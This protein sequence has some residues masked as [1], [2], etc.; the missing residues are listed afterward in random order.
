L[1]R[2]RLR[3]G[4]PGRRGRLCGRVRALDVHLGAG[5]DGL[6]DVLV[7]LGQPEGDEVDPLRQERGA[8]VDEFRELGHGLDE[9]R[10]D[11]VPD[12]LRRL[13]PD[14]GGELDLED[15][16]WEQL[17][18]R[19][20]DRREWVVDP[21]IGATPV[22]VRPVDAVKVVLAHHRELGVERDADG[23]VAGELEC[24][25]VVERSHDCY[26][27]NSIPHNYTARPRTRTELAGD[28][29]ILDL[30]G[31]L[32]HPLDLIPRLLAILDELFKL[33]VHRVPPRN[34]VVRL[35]LLDRET[36]FD[37]LF[38]RPVLTM[39]LAFDKDLRNGVSPSAT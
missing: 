4:R 21:E 39:G 25:A 12:P 37:R 29:R 19:G 11:Q 10:V 14:L 27:M 24:R 38:A 30:I 9:M 13:L 33:F 34:K 35:V 7:H 23:G 2:R 28:D 22:A 8:A 5:R 6:A 26:T 1:Y 31:E 36:L 32:L 17:P 3:R 20:L 15:A 18:L 16:I